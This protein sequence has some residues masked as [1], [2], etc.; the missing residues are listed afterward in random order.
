[1]NQ[2]ESEDRADCGSNLQALTINVVLFSFSNNPLSDITMTPSPRTLAVTKTANI[3]RL[4]LA[5]PP[6]PSSSTSLIGRK[7]SI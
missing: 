7:M 2:A 6:L 4:E 1:M 3:A 5:L